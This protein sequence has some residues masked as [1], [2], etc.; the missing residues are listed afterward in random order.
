VPKLKRPNTDTTPKLPSKFS[1]TVNALLKPPGPAPAAEII[2]VN[3]NTA[4]A[5]SKRAAVRSR[6]LREAGNAACARLVPALRK[7][8]L[9]ALAALA[10]ALAYAVKHGR[11]GAAGGET[12][13]EGA[14][15]RR[16]H[17]LG[18]RDPL[19][20]G[21]GIHAPT[22]RC[23]HC[24]ARL[25]VMHRNSANTRRVSYHCMTHGALLLD[26]EGR[27]LKERLTKD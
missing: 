8:R 3:A 26:S 10:R 19:S 23:P 27:L 11:R 7:G 15:V 24:S 13:L 5:R 18:Q 14:F 17:A 16:N 22:L 2:H 1:A 9:R 6:E 4:L 12:G 20:R 25:I 21:V